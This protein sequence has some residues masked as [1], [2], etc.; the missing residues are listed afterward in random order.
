MTF[1]SFLF[2]V[3][4][5]AVCISAICFT[6]YGGHVDH[7]NEASIAGWLLIVPFCVAAMVYA[8]KNFYNN[9]IGGKASVKEGFTCFS[10]S[11]RLLGT[12]G[13]LVFTAD[14]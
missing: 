5:S 11:T 10:F 13:T 7:I 1:K 14:F 2:P 4:Y 3:I 6:F 9:S 8:K 12:F